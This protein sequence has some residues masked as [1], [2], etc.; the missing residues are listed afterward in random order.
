MV[1]A[2]H[3]YPVQVQDRARVYAGLR[4]AGI[5]VQVHYVPVHQQPLYERPGG[6]DLP[7]TD[8]AYEGLLS[9]PLYPGLTESQ[10]DE[11]V[12]ALRAVLGQG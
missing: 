12:D 8:R 9:L 2:R 7:A 5:G 6:W 11:V 3:L 10:Q 4:D 1:H